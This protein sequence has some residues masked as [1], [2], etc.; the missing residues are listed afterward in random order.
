MPPEGAAAGAEPKMLPPGGAGAGVDPKAGVAGAAGA[1]VPG[2]LW[3]VLFP[4]VTIVMIEAKKWV[5]M[6]RQTGSTAMQC[7]AF[8]EWFVSASN[9]VW[10]LVLLFPGAIQPYP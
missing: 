8:G 7:D 5:R 1:G 9:C 3:T 6:V 4:Q 2:M 10:L